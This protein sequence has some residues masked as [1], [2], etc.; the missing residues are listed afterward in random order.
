MGSVEIMTGL[1][2]P[3]NQNSAKNWTQFSSVQSLSCGQLFGTPRT[4]ACQASLSFT[5]TWSLLK[6]MSIE[7]VMPS[8]HLILCHPLLLLPSNF[9]SIRVFSKELNSDNL[10]LNSEPLHLYFKCLWNKI[11]W[12]FVYM[13]SFMLMQWFDDMNFRCRVIAHSNSS[14]I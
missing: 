14:I 2:W 12:S 1:D 13:F 3:C 9:P 7:S 6:I 5:Y 10:N 11:P 8:N 4:A